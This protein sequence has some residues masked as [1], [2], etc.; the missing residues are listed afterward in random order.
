VIRSTIDTSILAPSIRRAHEPEHTLAPILRAW[1]AGQFELVLSEYIL[2]ELRR[3][4]T[5]PYFSR[6]LTPADQT[7]GLRLFQR[8]ATI[9]PITIEVTGVAAQPGD[10]LVLATAV[11]GR[12]D[13]L[14]TLDR[15]LLRL[16]V[17]EGVRIVGTREFLTILQDEVGG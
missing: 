15:Q 3:T 7:A 14:V 10:D 13:Y 2:D 9:T 1:R 16:G 5:K 8:S 6:Y 4:L 12:A 11:S 17:Y